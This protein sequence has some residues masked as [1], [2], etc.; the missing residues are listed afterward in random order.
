MNLQNNI[1][2]KNKKPAIKRYTRQ[3]KKHIIELA[4]QEKMP[5]LPE[6]VDKLKCDN[7]KAELV[8]KSIKIKR[9]QLASTLGTMLPGMHQTG[10]EGFLYLIENLAFDGWVKCGM[11]T[12]CTNRLRSYNGYDPMSGF[13]FIITKEVTDRR[14]A[15]I[16]LLHNVSLQATVRNGEWFKVDKNICIEI[17]NKIL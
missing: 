12:D 9:A 1:Y 16:L 17:F 14:K 4:S 6:I 8:F 11:T 13:S 10:K 15:E 7:A 3:L 5:T 2:A